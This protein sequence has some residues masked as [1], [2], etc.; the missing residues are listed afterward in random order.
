MDDLKLIKDKYGEKM[1]HFCRSAFPTIL[2][3]TG[4]LYNLL[5]D[6]FEFSRFLYEDIENEAAFDMFRKYIYSMLNEEQATVASEKTPKEL[7]EELGYD[8]YECKTEEEIQR[9]KIY[10]KKEEELC[11]FSGGRLKSCHVFFAV[12]KDAEIIQRKDEPKRQDE[13][14]TSVISIQFTKGDTNTLSIKNRYN[15]TVSNPDATFSNCLETITPGLTD[16]FEKTYNL[17]I[18]QNDSRSFELA[19]YVKANDGK[20]YK[21]NYEINNIYYCPNNII[22]DNYNVIRT[23]EE[24]EK[25]LVLDYFILDLVTKKIFEYDDLFDPFTD[26]IQNIKKIDIIKDKNTQN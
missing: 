22:I 10:Y 15:H 18:N 1:M 21:Y 3:T 24:K 25:Y 9:F 14:G 12:K 6:H 7:F 4:L 17:N 20:Y 2:E 11:T 13:Y 19:G 16:S 5:K 23:Y 26:S 8:F